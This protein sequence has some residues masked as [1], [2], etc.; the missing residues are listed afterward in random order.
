MLSGPCHSSP[1]GDSEEGAVQVGQQGLIVR[2]HDHAV[3]VAELARGITPD[4]ECVANERALASINQELQAA[5]TLGYYPTNRLE[6][7]RFRRI[8][9]EVKGRPRL[10]MPSANA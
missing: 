5:Y 1:G 2:H 7:G 10:S 8:D 9:V 3:N 4:Q 6:D